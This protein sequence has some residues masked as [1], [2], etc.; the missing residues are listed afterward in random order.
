MHSLYHGKDFVKMFCEALR[1]HIKN[2]IDFRKEIM[3]QL[4]KKELNLIQGA[5]G[6]YIFRKKKYRKVCKR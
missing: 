2:I 6:Y 4:T 1:E 5:T 3:L